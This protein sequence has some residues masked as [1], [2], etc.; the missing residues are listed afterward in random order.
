MKT[1]MTLALA[2]LAGSPGLVAADTFFTLSQVQE[3]DGLVDLGTIST[4]EDGIVQIYSLDGGER[5]PLLGYEALRAGANSDTKV[6]LT[7]TPRNSA[8]AELVVDGMV[9]AS[10]RLRFE[11]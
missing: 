3:R 6:R 5:G 2:I 1:L 7:S 11:D 10:Q 4:D 8:M 9:V